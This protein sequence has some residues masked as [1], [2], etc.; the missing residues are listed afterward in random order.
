MTA[1][2]YLDAVGHGD[3]LE[4][5]LLR[6]LSDNRRIQSPRRAMHPNAIDRV[7]RKHAKALGLDRL[8]E[9][10]LRIRCAPPL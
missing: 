4:G 8:T 2:A 7:L 10:I 9:A 6:P 3:D 5:P 1:P